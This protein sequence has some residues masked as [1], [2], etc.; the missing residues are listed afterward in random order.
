MDQSKMFCL[1]NSF[2]YDMIMQSVLCYFIFELKVLNIS[3]KMNLIVDLEKLTCKLIF[4][5]KKKKNDISLDLI[6]YYT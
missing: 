5:K 4:V 2:E 6:G 1:W 3:K